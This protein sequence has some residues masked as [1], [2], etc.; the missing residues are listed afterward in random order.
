M[1]FRHWK[2]S[3]IL[4]QDLIKI[5][6]VVEKKKLVSRM[7][8]A[9]ADGRKSNPLSS[10]LPLFHDT[11]LCKTFDELRH[12]SDKAPCTAF[13]GRHVHWLITMEKA[14]NTCKEN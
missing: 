12:M 1:V 6:A 11:S 7:G 3:W 13:T 2:A 14:T 5:F 9:V 10:A 4:T 8:A